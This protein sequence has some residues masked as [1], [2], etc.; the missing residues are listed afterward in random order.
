MSPASCTL[1]MIRYL[2]CTRGSRRVKFLRRSDRAEVEFYSGFGL[3]LE[4]RE[5]D[6]FRFQEK[7]IPCNRSLQISSEPSHIEWLPFRVF[8]KVLSLPLLRFIV[9]QFRDVQLR[10]V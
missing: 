6:S 9:T 4:G 8:K 3:G 5:S 1:D 2:S 7:R 10:F